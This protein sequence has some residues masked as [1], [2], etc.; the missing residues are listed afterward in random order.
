MT[1][2]SGV[3]PSR[4]LACCDKPSDKGLIQSLNIYILPVI[5]C[6]GKFTNLL[7]FLWGDHMNSYTLGLDIGSKS[8]GWAIAEENRIVDIGVRVFPEGVDRDTKGLEKSK[9]QTR[10]EARQSRR[11]RW[12]RKMRRDKLIRLLKQ[13]NLL[14]NKEELIKLFQT[15]DPYQL[16]AKAIHQRI[17][18]FDIGRCFY[19]IN[20]RRG[21][22]SNHRSGKAEEGIVKKQASQLQKDIESNNCKTLGEYLAMLDPEVQRRRERYTFRSMYEHEFDLIWQTQQQYYPDI[23]TDDFKAELKD[24][25]I[26]Y[27]RPLKPSDHL[28]GRCELE[29]NQ[30]RCP[31]G[32]YFAIKFRILQDINNLRVQNPDGTEL[33]LTQE[34]RALLLEELEKKKELS[35]D[36]IR[37]KLGLIDSQKFNLETGKQKKLKGNIFTSAMQKIVGAKNWKNLEEDK[38]IAINQALIELDDDELIEYLQ[39]AYKFSE[40]QIEKMLQIALPKGYMNFSRVAI[41]NLIPFMEQGLLTHEAIKQAGYNNDSDSFDDTV[42]FLPMPDDLRNPLVNK[43]LHETRKLINAIIR[44]YGKPA[45]IKIEMSRDVKGS[46]RE[47]EE[48]HYRMLENQKRNDEIRKRLIEDIGIKNPSRDD[49]IKYKLWEECDGICPYTGKPISQSALFGPNP[50]FQIEHILPYSRSLDDSYMN[51]TLCFIEEN[52]RKG[53]KTPYEFYHGTPQFDEIL[54]R[55][56]KLPY[57][58]KKRKFW[59][60]EISLDECI[61]RELNDNR[62][63]C[64]QVVSYLKMLGCS[65]SGTRGKVTADL[66][67]TW[68]LNSILNLLHPNMKNRDDYRHHAIDAA[69][70]AV[71]NNK[72]LRDLAFSKTSTIIRNFPEPWDGFRRELAEKIDNIIVSHKVTKRVRGQLHEETAYGLLNKV[73]QNQAN[74]MTLVSGEFVYRKKLEDLTIPAVKEIVD[75]VVKSIIIQRL[76][77]FG[78]DINKSSSIPK[79]VWNEPLYMKCKTGKKIPIKKVRIKTVGNN[80]ILLK[81]KNTGKFYRAVKPGNNHHI[82]IF[83][84]IDENGVIKREGRVITLFEATQRKLQGKPIID[85]TYKPNWRFVCSLAAN[86]MFMLNVNG[87]EI[88]YRV[89]KIDRTGRIVLRPHTYAGQLKDSD[90]PPLI[91]RKTPNTLEGYKI[92]VDRLGRIYPA[93]D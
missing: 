63:I 16:R 65:V 51:K 84:H 29:P 48:L 64:R 8:I 45:K 57:T 55:I 41:Q 19:H 40:D 62:Y 31:R 77:Q 28:I 60:K 93:N 23:L 15:K 7:V 12:R 43:A 91:Q 9:N 25:T 66:R 20:Q 21:F 90:K 4:F 76:Q 30:P 81:D 74:G 22:K 73:E 47:R 39:S 46:K 67:Y 18:P 56:G 2:H 68:G 87:E 11:L 71:T 32:D 10:R 17:D 53:D 27:Q 26:F 13:K 49:I 58:A 50:E 52:R 6:Q 88:P 92:H 1:P 79:N 34:Q 89:Q 59:Q 85:K 24:K 5:V 3:K 33:Q 80:L 72:H 37:R 36:Q 69:V 82:E 61:A 86:E 54:K 35:W 78:V 70:V 44:Q 14:P 42:D 75:P 83:E 38:K